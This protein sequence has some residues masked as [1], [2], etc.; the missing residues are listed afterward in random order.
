MKEIFE[1]KLK[2]VDGRASPSF[3][4]P[5]IALQS[6]LTVLRPGVY[7]RVTSTTKVSFCR[8][9]SKVQADERS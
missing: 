8:V 5:Y 3:E 9:K 6:L 4:Q 2:V 7:H 1:A